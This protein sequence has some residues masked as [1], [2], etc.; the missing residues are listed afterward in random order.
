MPRFA[1]GIAIATET[2]TTAATIA[3]TPTASNY[4]KVSDYPYADL[5]QHHHLAS[6]APLTS[7]EGFKLRSEEPVPGFSSASPWPTLELGMEWGRKLYPS[8]GPRS[9]GGLM[10]G[11]PPSAADMNQPRGPMTSL[12][13][14]PL[15]AGRWAMQPVVDQTK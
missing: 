7:A 6:T 14:E 1:V 13:E 15:G 9:A 2:F 11:L 8:A 12:K 10:F 3:T 5:H 4:T